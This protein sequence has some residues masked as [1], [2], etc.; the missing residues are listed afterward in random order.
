MT[1]GSTTVS[2][3]AILAVEGATSVGTSV[4][5]VG[6]NAQLNETKNTVAQRK[7]NMCGYPQV[8]GVGCHQ[9]YGFEGGY[10]GVCRGTGQRPPPA[11]CGCSWFGFDSL[12]APSLVR[13]G[14]AFRLI[15]LYRLISQVVS[16]SFNA[17]TYGVVQHLP[18]FEH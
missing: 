5:S 17:R 9:V 1:L 11:A 6:S 14:S 18:S 10:K 13:R 16:E 15:C 4:T 2:M 8:P 3:T 12:S 7:S